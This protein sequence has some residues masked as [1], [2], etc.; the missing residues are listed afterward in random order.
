MHLCGACIYTSNLTEPSH[1]AYI[2]RKSS[3][4]QAVACLFWILMSVLTGRHCACTPLCHWR[5]ST[6]YIFVGRRGGRKTGKETRRRGDGTGKERKREERAFV[7]SGFCL[8]RRGYSSCQ[9]QEAEGLEACWG[10]AC[11]TGIFHMWALDCEIILSLS[12]PNFCESMN[13]ATVF[14]YISSAP[15]IK[16][17]NMPLFPACIYRNYVFSLKAY[18][19]E[20]WAFL[21]SGIFILFFCFLVFWFFLL[22]K[23]QRKYVSEVGTNHNGLLYLLFY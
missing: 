23:N 17:K 13:V 15:E 2:L 3:R 19:V 16:G 20:L 6:F 11:V 10:L 21:C 7:F 5:Q 18:L 12:A 8:G 1:L 22:C 14:L 9:G 4:S